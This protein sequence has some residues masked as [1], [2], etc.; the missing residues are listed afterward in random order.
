MIPKNRISLFIVLVA[1]GASAAFA[2]QTTTVTERWSVIS[3]DD[4]PVGSVHES[5]TVGVN[6]VEFEERSYI[7]LNRMGSKVEIATR[8]LTVE[9]TTGALQTFRMVQQTSEQEVTMQAHLRDG[10]W[11]MTQRAG[12]R[13]FEQPLTTEHELIGPVEALRRIDAGLNHPGDK[14]R[15]HSFSP[16]S[17]QPARF[18]ARLTDLEDQ[19]GEVV[20]VVEER[21]EG[22]PL[23]SVRRLNSDG[24]YV[25][26]AMPGPL[27]ET[28]I[29]LADQLAAEL[30]NQ[31]GELPEESYHTTLLKTGYRLPRARDIEY[32]ELELTHRNPAL[33]WPDLTS[34]AQQVLEQDDDR[35]V[36]A[37]V[38]QTPTRDRSGLSQSLAGF[39][40][41]LQA[42]AWLQSDN[43]DA[44]T[45]ASEITGEETDAWQAARKLER[46]VAEN[47]EFDMG[48]VMA[49]SSE[50]LS[51]RRGTCTEYAVL[52]STLARAADIPSRVVMGYVYVQGIFGGHAWTEVLID[53]EWIALDGAI[54]SRG[55]ADAARFAFQWSSLNEGAA[56]F[57]AGPAVQL[58]GQ[59][60]ARI[61]A[62]RI[63]GKPLVHVEV[64]DPAITVNDSRFID[65]GL[66]VSWKASSG[67]A[68]VDYDRT[69]PDSLIVALT[70]GDGRR[71]ELRQLTRDWW[72][73]DPDF[74]AR[75]VE[76]RVSAG[77]TVLMNLNGHRA[78]L[79]QANGQA[80]IAL[81]TG[82]EPWLLHGSGFH[83][84]DLLQ[85]AI[86]GLSFD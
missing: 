36:L 85:A 79:R 7:A 33:G 48:V 39:E 73:D 27:G 16:I 69:W 34:S 11:V 25:A 61:R 83:S 86:A 82:G 14:V 12:D 68:F 28:K 31:G 57:N 18:S 8:L 42:N 45:L 22:T 70:D 50:V 54:P 78:F 20:R 38:R 15:Y 19:G 23:V 10:Q 56:E 53:D 51:N 77:E 29:V 1:A 46:W 17:G 62:Y 30:A 26:T 80:F 49:P 3:I 66:G 55:S 59:I 47:M 64:D 71:L 35:L 24:V 52:L 58:F 84:E 43:D 9:S 67:M 13:Q 21:I 81:E 44:R 60:D 6:G 72:Q 65:H 75:L 2:D 4:R 40:S 37:I 5:T 41:Y 63:D 32:L 74:L 76:R